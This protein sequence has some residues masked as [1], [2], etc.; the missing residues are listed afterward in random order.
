MRGIR[1]TGTPI[2][3]S[4]IW[5]IGIHLAA[6][7]LTFA[8]WQITGDIRWIDVF[9][10][11]QGSLFFVICA[12]AELWL[13]WTALRQFSPGEPM[14]AAWMLITVASFYRFTG[15]LFTQILSVRSYLNPLLLISG[16][17]DES[18]FLTCRRFG[19]IVS[20]PL[21]MAVLAAGL[22]LILRVLR[23]L[24]ILSRPRPLDLLFISCVL[25]FTV[26]QAYE[27]INWLRVT[28]APYDLQK[29]LNWASDPLLSILLVEAVLIRRPA[30]ITGWGLLAKSWQAFAAAI[31]LTS[32]GD[33]GLWATAHDYLPWPYSSVTWYVWF[34]ASAAYVLGPAYQVEACR[35]AFREAKVPKMGAGPEQV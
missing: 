35:R 25:A 27:I 22:F 6:S 23:R 11:Y 17:T 9:F 7:A 29:V 20:G 1:A 10:K 14:R 24:G 19:L 34:L 3:S 13:A 5:L 21:H 30:L 18:L 2:V 4:A 8:A 16:A 15:F 32:L 33:I 26:R 12:A 31:F 28:A